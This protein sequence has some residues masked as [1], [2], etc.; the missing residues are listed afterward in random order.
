LEA[1]LVANRARF[2]PVLW[3][4]AAYE[5]GGRSVQGQQKVTQCL[6]QRPALTLTTL[7]SEEFSEQSQ[8]LK[9]QADIYQA[10]RRA[11]LPIEQ[12]DEAGEL[13]LMQ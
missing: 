4:A 11:G 5:I 3:L 9:A 1:A 10:L 6:T 13:R 2:H 8:Y 12:A 7:R